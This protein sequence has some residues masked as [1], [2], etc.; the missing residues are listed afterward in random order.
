MHDYFF[1]IEFEKSFSKEQ[2]LKNHPKFKSFFD[3][4]DK[5]KAEDLNPEE[6]IDQYKVANWKKA[7]S[8]PLA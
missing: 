1:F 8:F 4:I 2:F 5:I 6:F 3:V 7:G